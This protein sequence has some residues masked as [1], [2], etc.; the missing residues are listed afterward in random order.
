M[1]RVQSHHELARLFVAHLHNNE[2]SLAGVT[3]TISLAIIL[4]ATRS[5]NV[6]EKWYKGQDLNEDYYEPYIKPQ[7]RN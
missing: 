6:G 3:F 2:V 1:E 5:P 4:G 7:Y